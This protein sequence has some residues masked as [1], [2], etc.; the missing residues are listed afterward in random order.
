MNERGGLT[1]FFDDVPKI[2]QAMHFNA[3]TVTVEMVVE[4]AIWVKLL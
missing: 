2:N 1:Q 3:E 4:Q